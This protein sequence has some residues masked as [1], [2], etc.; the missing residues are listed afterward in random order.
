MFFFLLDYSYMLHYTTQLLVHFKQQQQWQFKHKYNQHV[1]SI[2]RSPK[3]RYLCT[4]VVI[5]TQSANRQ[6]SG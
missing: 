5:E 3:Y 4:N 6:K 1:Y 2:V